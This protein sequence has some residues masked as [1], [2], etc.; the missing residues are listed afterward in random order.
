MTDV[1]TA[2]SKRLT[3]DSGPWHEG[4]H[5][6]RIAVRLSGLDTNGTYT[7]VEAN[8]SLVRDLDAVRC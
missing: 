1:V 2:S 3:L 7:I 6:E 4:I 8:C 5:G